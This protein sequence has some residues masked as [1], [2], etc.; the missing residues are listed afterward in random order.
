M[1]AKTHHLF[2]ERI[3]NLRMVRRMT[4]RELAKQLGKS[5][6]YISKI[7]TKGEVPNAELMCKMAE[8][9][10][11]QPESLL[12]LAKKQVLYKTEEQILNRHSKALFLF[13]RAK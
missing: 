13:R 2:G 10:D 3:K 8:I 12:E 7:E 5:A 9:L 6:G 4:V 11:V 1:D